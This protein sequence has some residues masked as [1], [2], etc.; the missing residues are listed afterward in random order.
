MVKNCLDEGL[1]PELI[2]RLTGLTE[3]ELDGIINPK[4]PLGQLLTNIYF[5]NGHH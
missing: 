4:C 5:S 3:E 2:M 1:E